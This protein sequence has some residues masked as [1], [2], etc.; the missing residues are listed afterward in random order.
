MIAVYVDVINLYRVDEGD[1]LRQAY[2]VTGD[3]M[4]RAQIRHNGPMD[5]LYPNRETVLEF[6]VKLGLGQMTHLK[7]EPVRDLPAPRWKKFEY[8]P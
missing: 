4:Y 1:V 2:V 6:G 7:C 3:A 5:T 8:R